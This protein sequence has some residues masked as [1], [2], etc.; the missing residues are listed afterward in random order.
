MKMFIP[1]ERP[2]VFEILMTK[3]ELELLNRCGFCLKYGE[4]IRRSYLFEE[5]FA[6]H[7]SW[8]YTDKRRNE[9]I[10]PLL[11]IL[12]Q[13]LNGMVLIKERT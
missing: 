8:L 11:E 9:F 1:K 13:D 5:L 4:K 6:N 2:D 12:Q 7:A 3:K 10:C